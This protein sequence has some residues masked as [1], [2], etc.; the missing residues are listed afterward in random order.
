MIRIIENL[1]EPEKTAILN[2]LDRDG[3][4]SKTFGTYCKLTFEELQDVNSTL[5]SLV[6]I[7]ESEVDVFLDQL[8]QIETDFLRAISRTKDKDGLKQIQ[9]KVRNANKRTRLHILSIQEKLKADVEDEKSA[10]QKLKNIF[11]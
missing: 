6:G 3:L 4:K 9:L 1:Q 5:M 2:Q 7:G 10:F 8:N 11:Q